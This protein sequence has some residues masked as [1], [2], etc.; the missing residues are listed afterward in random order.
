MAVAGLPEPAREDKG[1]SVEFP[2]ENKQ[3]VV[4]EMDF[5]IIEDDGLSVVLAPLR[6]SV[7]HSDFQ[8]ELGDRLEAIATDWRR[9][10]V[11]RDQHD[12][13]AN[14]IE[15]HRRQV[16]VATNS[17]MIREAAD[18]VIDLKSELFGLT[19][20]GS[21]AALMEAMVR[22]EVEAE[23]IVTR[24]GR[25]LVRLHVYRERDRVFSRRVREH[26]RSLSGGKLVCQACGCVPNDVYGPSGE[27]SIETHHKVPIEQLQPD[28]VTRVGDMA[29]LCASCHRVVHSQ[30]PCLTVEDVNEMVAAR[31][32]QPDAEGQ[33]GEEGR[34]G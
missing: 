5:D 25:L 27:S 15:A 12:A 17:N 26:F 32:R 31:R 6:A 10:N 11:I 7:L 21:T 24:E 3:F 14:A 34:R 18:V 22:P 20:A 2:L 29:V 16:S 23:E 33:R 19:N 8:V 4:D 1:S 9:I 13:L 28:S 30:K